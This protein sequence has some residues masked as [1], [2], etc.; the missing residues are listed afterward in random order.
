MFNLIILPVR[1]VRDLGV[2]TDANVT[3]NAHVTA[4]VKACFA[5]LRQIRSVH[6]SPVDTIVRALVVRKVDYCSSVL[7]GISGQLLQRLQYV[8]NTA[9]HLA[10]SARKSERF[11]VN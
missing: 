1:S 6:R 9:A 5:A 8:F 4:I 11:S 2:C 7:C 10:F 3:M